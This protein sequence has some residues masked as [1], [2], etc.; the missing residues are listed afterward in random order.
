MPILWALNTIL[1]AW[2]S[3]YQQ[4]TDG[5][6]TWDHKVTTLNSAK[7]IANR[8]QWNIGPQGNYFKLSQM[9]HKSDLKQFKD[10]MQ[11]NNK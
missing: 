5:S 1:W 11:L 6:E 7:W 4:Q 8:R 9:D 2:D 3:I 10:T